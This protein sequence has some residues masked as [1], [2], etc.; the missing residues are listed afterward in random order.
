M[1]KIKISGILILLLSIAILI[2]TKNISDHTAI[3]NNLLETI[4]KQKAFTQE[5]SKNIF[6]IYKNKQA[7]SKQLDKSIKNFIFN[8]NNKKARLEKM[9]SKEIRRQ[10]KLITNLWNRFYL[11]IQKFRNQNKTSN[12]YNNIILE[13]IVKNIY[14]ENLK[15]IVEF[16]KLISLHN[17][18]FHN[19][20]QV[21][22]TIQYILFLILFF[23]L[24]YFIIYI[25]KTTSNFDILMKKIDD[26]IQS[27]DQIESNSENLLDG[28]E[29]SQEE[30][31]IIE[32]LD[33]LMSSSIKLKKL[34]IDLENLNKLKDKN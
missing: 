1:N 11:N 33:E 27:I 24:I 30:D 12:P 34:K 23:V 22:K 4:N 25:S 20:H 5:I 17:H 28:T 8:T 7:S 26:S 14:D 31:A 15:L 2:I 9:E 18:I 32:A 10:S 3:N 16:N 21:H 6:Y 19:E 29:L 13:K